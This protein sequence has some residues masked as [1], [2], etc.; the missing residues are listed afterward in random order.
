MS[1]SLQHAVGAF[2]DAHNGGDGLIATA[3]GGLVLMR[4]SSA[5]PTNRLPNHMIYRPALCVVVQ[6]AKQVMFGDHVLEFGEMQAIVVSLD[7]PAFGTVAKASPQKP[8]LAIALDFDVAIL[9]EVMDELQSPPK[10]AAEGGLG[11]YIQNIDGPLADCML[12]LV[13]LLD[14]PHAIPVLYPAIMREIYFWLLTGA[15]AADICKLGLPDSHTQRIAQAIRVLRENF[16]R[17]M[18]IAQLAAAA[19]MSA[20]SFH[21]HFKMLTSMTP[22]QYQKQLRLLEARR[23]LVADG[24]NVA[25]AA[26]RVGYESASQF[27]REYA[28]MFGVPPKRDATEL[29]SELKYELSGAPA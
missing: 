4:A 3:I 21:Q 2:I 12:R 8:Y 5:E 17:P 27:S 14:T 19:R 25:S 1:S 10:P 11:V 6:G 23:L 9:R 18:R 29:K 7:L 13:R 28:R 16:V 24:S 26:H 20:S 22:L 15:N